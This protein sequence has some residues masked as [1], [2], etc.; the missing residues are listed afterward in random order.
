MLTGE[1]PRRKLEEGMRKEDAGS[2]KTMAP[3]EAKN[4]KS[5]PAGAR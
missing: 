4:S 3:Q 2:S 1:E 5:I